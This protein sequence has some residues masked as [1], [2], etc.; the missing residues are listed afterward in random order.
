MATYNVDSGPGI[1][2]L[3]RTVL[4]ANVLP[5]DFSALDRAVE[6]ENDIANKSLEVIM[7]NVKNIGRIQDEL[8]GITSPSAY[9]AG[10]LEAAKKS[11]GIDRSAMVN[12][13]SN[14]DNPLAAYDLDRKMKRLASDPRV[15]E[16][17]HDNAVIEAYK[18]GLP[19]ITDPHLRTKAI[20]DL[21]AA[22]KSPDRNAIKDLNLHQYQSI[23]L[24]SA[25]EEALDRFAPYIPTQEQVPGPNGTSYTLTVNKRDPEMVAKTREFFMN[26]RTVKNNLTAKGYIDDAGKPMPA[27]GNSTWFDAFEAPQLIP[28]EQISN[29]KGATGSG[30]G[31]KYAYT[32]PENLSGVQYKSDIHKDDTTGMSFDLGIISGV[33]TGNRAPQN[34]VHVDPNGKGINLGAYSF[35]ADTGKAFLDFLQPHVSHLPDAIVAYEELKNIPLK[36]GDVKANAARAKLAYDKIEKAI[37]QDTLV[38]LENEFAIDT[39]G[40]PVIDYVQSREGLENKSLSPG[41]ATLLMDA[42]IQW[43]PK[44]WKKWI[45]EYSNLGP[46]A[47]DIA[48]F[49]TK[50]RIAEAATNANSGMYSHQLAQQ[51]GDRAVKVWEAA[52]RM[53]GGTSTGPTP[54]AQQNPQSG[55]TA[56]DITQ[57]N[58]FLDPAVSAAADSLNATQ[59][60][61]VLG[62]WGHTKATTN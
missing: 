18:A 6:T 22:T 11:H 14:I 40:T 48:E 37:G 2:D 23:D 26:E 60:T 59:Q 12:V 3:G 62:K 51:I 45:D 7:E 31:G 54:A 4:P 20:A 10:E 16:I 19:N 17:M 41:E 44:T 21:D 55:N 46:N 38:K 1:D 5:F 13:V 53:D 36:G 32:L 43:S 34:V 42:A 25:Y 49:I 47:P 15:K 30:A 56:M 27:F 58:Q 50:K 35:H 29:V 9:H 52:T 33:E 39:F 57:F 61:D 28:I 8:T 24:E